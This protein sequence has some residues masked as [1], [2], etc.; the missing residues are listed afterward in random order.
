MVY[1]IGVN[2]HMVQC[3]SDWMDMLYERM[4]G[5]RLVEELRLSRTQFAQHLKEQAKKLKI[6]LIAEEANEEKLCEYKAKTCTGRD[7]SK[8]LGIEHRFC[9]P[10]SSERK[11]LGIPSEYEI[12]ERLCF[13]IGHSDEV[14]K[15]NEK[16]WPRREQFWFNKIR[17]KIDEPIV[18]IC[19]SVHLESFKLL[20]TDEGCRAKILSTN[21]GSE[22]K[23]VKDEIASA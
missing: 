4:F 6:T 19:G 5:R 8:E 15:L 16:Y 12:K 22:N 21:W 3:T 7:I 17:D 2:D 20:L 10:N 18:F 23:G 11:N 13:K 1:L 14:N 9:D